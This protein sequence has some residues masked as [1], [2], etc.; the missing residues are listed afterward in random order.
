M[1]ARQFTW[2]AVAG[3]VGLVADAGVL[4]L[5][6]WSGLGPYAG[7]LLSLLAAVF[8]TWRINRRH[9]FTPLPGEPAWREGLRYLMAMALGAVVNYAAYSVAYRLAE[10]AWPGAAWTSHLAL[11]AGVPLGMIS[12]FLTARYWVYRKRPASQQ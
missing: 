9:T 11:L 12:N 5:A 4:A 10:L 3:V 2:F 1:I 6:L 7:R 8:V